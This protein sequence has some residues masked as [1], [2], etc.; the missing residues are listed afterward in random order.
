[1]IYLASGGLFSFN[2]GFAIWVLISMVIFLFI[3]AKFAVPPIMAALDEREKNIKDSLESAEN[4]LKEAKQISQD[5]QKALK[6]AEAEAQRI[7]KD[8][9]V[10][11]ETIRAERVG[12]V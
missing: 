5:N 8:A 11:A 3:M 4:A 10:G 9:L 1:M 12:Q 2:T 6:Q 7:R